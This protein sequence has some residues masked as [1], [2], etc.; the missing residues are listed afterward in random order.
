MA[1]FLGGGRH[2]LGGRRGYPLTFDSHDMMLS[3]KE[4]HFKYI[5]EICWCPYIVLAFL[6]GKM[7][8]FPFI[9]WPRQ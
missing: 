2:C 3:E 6:G 7:T 8:F 9:L 4:V 5:V 1:L